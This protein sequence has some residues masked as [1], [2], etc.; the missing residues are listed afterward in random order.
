MMVLRL[1]GRAA[2][3]LATLLAALAAVAPLSARAALPPSARIVYVSDETGNYDIYTVGVDGSGRQRLTADASDDFDPAWSPDGSEIAFV[4]NSGGNRDIWL[5]NADGSDQRRIT[6]DAA[7]QRFPAWSPDGSQIAFRS[8]RSPST[9]FDI[10]VMKADGSSPTRVTADPALWGE[11]LETSPSWSPDR[12]LAFVS[13]RDGN[14]EIYEINEDGSHPRRLTNNNTSD[15]FPAWSPDGSRIAFVSDRTGNED[16][17]TMRASD[18]RGETNITND[19]ASDRY[20]AW[21]PDSAQIAFRSSR[22]RSFD[23]YRMDPDGSGVNRLTSGL[24]RQIEPGFQGFALSTGP[25]GPDGPSSDR[26]TASG[27]VNGPAAGGGNPNHVEGNSA[28][29][30]YGLKVRIAK[31]QRVLRR[32]G[33]VLYARC[34]LAC[35]L[36]VTGTLRVLGT[37][38]TVS[39]RG[40]RR[41]L[42][43]HQTTRLKLALPP[44]QARRVARLLAQRQRLQ[45][46]IAIRVGDAPTAAPITLRVLTAR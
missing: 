20:P 3:G 44:R 38:Q 35:P 4:R 27:A 17:F 28:T 14:R 13:D 46:R 39:L 32:G 43:A 31:R 5:M 11:S 19:P 7:S 16:I 26:G 24:G 40:V 18:G 37:R 29:R 6:T 42:A 41:R 45:V 12:K 34:D 15:Q 21:S 22:N 25:G 23:I 8:N 1:A 36:A 30:S 2:I 9:S 33:V 10:W